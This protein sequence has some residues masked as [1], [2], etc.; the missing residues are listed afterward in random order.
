MIRISN[1]SAGNN[2]PPDFS[3]WTWGELQ[4][5]IK[6]FCDHVATVLW[7]QMQRDMNEP[8]RKATVTLVNE[9]GPAIDLWALDDHVLTIPLTDIEILHDDEEPDARQ[10]QQLIDVF[11]GWIKI[12]EDRS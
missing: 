12:L 7:T 8:W 2:D 5:Q 11:K 1:E 10:R 3:T 6:P 4:Q 9:D